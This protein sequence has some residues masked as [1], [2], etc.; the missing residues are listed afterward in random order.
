MLRPRLTRRTFLRASG[1]LA[2]AA[3]L[4]PAW[5]AQSAC[6]MAPDPGRRRLVVIQLSGGND[7]LN[8]LAPFADPRYRELR[9]KIGIGAEEAVRMTNEL[10]WHPA[11]APLQDLLEA[12]RLAVLQGVGY[13]NAHRSH[14]R[15][16]D[17]WHAGAT[18]GELAA[19]GWLGRYLDN[20]CAGA[21]GHTAVA[22]SG[23]V[24]PAL[25]GET[26]GA[27]ALARIG[28]TQQYLRGLDAVDAAPAAALADDAYVAKLLADARTST[29]YLLDLRRRAPA[30]AGFPK[31]KLGRQL[32]QIAQLLLADA[33]TTVYYADH[34]SFDTHAGQP[35]RHAKLLAEYAEAVAAFTNTLAEAGLLDDTFVLTFSEFGRRAAQNRNGGTDHGKANLTWAIGGRVRPTPPAELAP[36]LAELDDGDLAMRTDF[37]SVYATVLERWWGVDSAE[38]LGERY[39]VLDFV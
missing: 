8:T 26:S 31:T 21:P 24:P 18:D 22:L 19:T 30:V 6:A 38:V 29:D 32:R 16:M 11:L 1:T 13:P 5:L 3:P 12:G 39:Q 17:V 34:G 14:F 25:Q 35:G 9:P 27:Y 15:S 7:G 4:L 23:D 37:R 28:R 10:G 20:H 33:E 36:D 2:T